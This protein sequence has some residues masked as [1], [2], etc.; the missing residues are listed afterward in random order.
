M[1]IPQL[2]YSIDEMALYL[3]ELD[4][5]E[6]RSV[7]NAIRGNWNGAAIAH[8]WQVSI[9]QHVETKSLL[10]RDDY[11][12]EHTRMIDDPDFDLATAGMTYS[13]SWSEYDNFI[14][15]LGG[16]YPPY[17][18][19]VIP[20]DN[21]RKWAAQFGI[22]LWFDTKAALASIDKENKVDIVQNAEKADIPQ[23]LLEIQKLLNGENEH[24][25]YAP[26]LAI[27]LKVWLAAIS[28]PYA[29]QHN[30][31]RRIESHI[32]VSVTHAAARERIAKVCN[33]NKDGNR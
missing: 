1:N 10:L 17:D 19:Q 14:R 21:I 5:Y 27:A 11:Y 33:W 9:S 3:A 20:I 12:I 30:A 7:E 4:P 2:F 13:E 24:E 22:D 6:V 8:K 29:T 15:E 26:E 28:D 18:K 25:F 23:D 16:T 31:K 32:P